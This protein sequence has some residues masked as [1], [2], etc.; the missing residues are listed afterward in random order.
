LGPQ[1]KTNPVPLLRGKG[2][3][4]YS[5]KRRRNEGPAENGGR[6]NE[7]IIREGKSRTEIKEGNNGGSGLKKRKKEPKVDGGK[8]ASGRRKYSL[9]KN[10]KREYPVKKQKSQQ[11]HRVGES[12][13]LGT[14]K[15]SITRKK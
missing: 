2:I 15:G 12:A 11:K 9:A 10:E 13:P 5:L 14:S 7:E 3:R 1:C 4:N 8:N 6:A